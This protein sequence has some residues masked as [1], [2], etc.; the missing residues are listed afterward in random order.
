MGNR[1]LQITAPHICGEARQAMDIAVYTR[2]SLKVHQCS[3]QTIIGKNTYK[4]PQKRL[5]DYTSIKLKKKNKTQLKKKT[6][7]T[8][9]LAEFF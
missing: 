1:S 9:F 6:E 8:I 5:T 3:L 4:Y 7:A 2:K